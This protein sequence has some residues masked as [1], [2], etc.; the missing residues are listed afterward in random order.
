MARLCDLPEAMAEHLRSLPLPEFDDTALAAGPPLAE[1][2]VAIVTSAGLVRR[3]EDAFAPGDADYRVIPGDVQGADL[4]MSHISVNYD[5]SGFVE[6]TNVVFPIDRLREL[7]AEGTIGSVA[8]HHY[9]FMGATDPEKM[10][11][12]AARVAGHLAADRV[13]AVLLTPV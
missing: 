2:R 7:E 5:R 12:P 6:D 11:A 10:A 4:L 9:S 13:D 1:R 3:G 8:E